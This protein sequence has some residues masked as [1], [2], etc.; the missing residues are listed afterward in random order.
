MKNIDKFSNTK[1]AIKAYEIYK[2]ENRQG[3]GKFVT[4]K[5]W[6]EKR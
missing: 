2:N 3:L 1:D 6:L 4:F 5:D